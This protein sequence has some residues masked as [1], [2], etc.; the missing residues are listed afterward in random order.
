MYIKNVCSIRVAFEFKRNSLERLSVASR[1]KIST[2]PRDHTNTQSHW[3]ACQCSLTRAIKRASMVLNGRHHAIRSSD[4][5]R[6]FWTCPC[7]QLVIL[8]CAVSGSMHM[9]SN[10]NTTTLCPPWRVVI[11]RLAQTSVRIYAFVYCVCV[12]RPTTFIIETS[13]LLFANEFRVFVYIEYNRA[14]VDSVHPS[15]FIPACARG[16]PNG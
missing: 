12:L 2:H 13:S 7:K 4:H 6:L 15:I 1:I 10:C 14:V 11:N 9:E 3:H 8:L 16:R 5:V